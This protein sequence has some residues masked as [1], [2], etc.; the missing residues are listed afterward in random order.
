MLTLVVLLV[1]ASFGNWPRQPIG[2][3]G[4]RRSVRTESN[5]AHLANKKQKEN[6]LLVYNSATGSSVLLRVG[7]LFFQLQCVSVFGI[8]SFLSREQLGLG[9]GGIRLVGCW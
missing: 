5:V 3:G 8:F 6:S 9:R 2:I 7:E 4:I 1:G